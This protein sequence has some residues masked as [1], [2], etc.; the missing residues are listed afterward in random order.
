MINRVFRRRT[1]LILGVGIFLLFLLIS[2]MSPNATERWQSPIYQLA[3]HTYRSIEKLQDVPYLAYIIRKNNL[4]TYNIVIDPRDITAMNAGLPKDMVKGRLLD[5][6]KVRVNALFQTTQYESKVKIRYRGRGPNHWNSLKKSYHVDFPDEQPF[7]GFESIKFNIPEDRGYVVEPLNFYRAEKFGM[8]APQPWF[9][10]LKLNGQAM[11]VYIAIPH[12]TTTLIE[13]NKRPETSNIFGIIDISRQETMERNFF[14]PVNIEYWEDYTKQEIP[15]ADKKALSE[16]LSFVTHASDTE[17]AKLLPAVVDMDAL[18]GWLIMNTLAA[19]THQ[20][21]HVNIILFRDTSTGKFQPIPWDTQLYP[22]EPVHLESHPLIGRTLSIPA[23]REEYLRRLTAY[24]SQENLTDDLA[25]YDAVWESIRIPLYQDFAKAPLS[26]ETRAS[27]IRSRE[28]IEKNFSRVHEVATQNPQ[29]LFVGDS[30]KYASKPL[31]LSVLHKGASDSLRTFIQRHPQFYLDG[32]DTI[33]IGPGTFSLTSTVIIPQNYR[34]VIKPGTRIS[35]HPDVSIV[36]FNNLTAIGTLTSPIRIENASQKPWGSLFVIGTR[37]GTSSVAYAHITGG[38]GFHQDGVTATGMLA[39]HDTNAVI[40]N[41]LFENTHDDDALNVKHG[42]VEISDNIFRNTFGDAIDLDEGR[43]FVRNN[44]F[45]NFGFDAHKSAGPNGDGIDISFST[46][47]IS[48]NI[49]QTCG[50]K[51][52]SV[53]EQSTPHIFNN[54]IIKCSIGIA[55]KDLS[56]ATISNNYL[57][58][59]TTGLSLSMKKPHFGGGKARITQTIFWNNE[60]DL[61]VDNKSIIHI[62]D[63]N[64]LQ[65]RNDKLILPDTIPLRFQSLLTNLLQ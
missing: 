60:Q 3:I 21:M 55:V 16:F 45:G 56:N 39:L 59:N 15:P 57:I 17:Y 62:F 54:L 8:V 52:I 47:D 1:I 53:G 41:T 4:P 58:G 2:I 22:Y 63:K 11:G 12:W 30:E 65:S 61:S 14:D 10:N 13:H 6:H 18:Y 48:E 35:L 32:T 42:Q 26:K 33:A 43:G 31:P 23:F 38:S 5:E 50:D 28:L 36:S 64:I 44:T 20:N 46:V 40:V 49:I 51:G 27:R 7:N 19:S 25:F 9:T 34:L 29:D 37:T 24:T